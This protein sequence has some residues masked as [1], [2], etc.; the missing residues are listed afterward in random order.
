M[1]GLPASHGRPAAADTPL[2]LTTLGAVRLTRHRPGPEHH[3]P[4]LLPPGK[5]LALVTYLHCSPGR[6]ASRDHLIEQFWND[7]GQADGRHAL[8]Q[9][10]LRIRH[11]LGADALASEPD[12]IAL[13]MPIICDRDEFRKA[14]AA[15]QPDQAVEI[16][17]GDFFPAFASPGA[18]GFEQWADLERE[19]LRRSFLRAGEE[20]VRLALDRAAFAIATPAAL[21]LRTLCPN[22]QATWRLL[23]EAYSSSGNQ[24]AALVEADGLLAALAAMDD[25]PD[26]AT[27]RLLSELRQPAPVTSPPGPHDHD[28]NPLRSEMVGRE[29]PFA[30]LTAA[31]EHIQRRGAQHL[32][33]CSPPG[34]GKTRLLQELANR[35][36]HTPGCVILLRAAQGDRDRPGALIGDIATALAATGALSGAARD[37]LTELAPLAPTLSAFLD[38]RTTRV[39]PQGTR[40]ARV[41]AL[42]DLIGSVADNRPLALLLD[43]LHWGD[44]ESREII[45]GIIP[46]LTT[47][48]V[49]IVTASRDRWPDLST[50]GLTSEIPL[51]SLHESAI[52]GMLSSMGA[53]PADQFT[54]TFARALLRTS[55]GSPLLVL[56]LLRLAIEHGHVEALPGGWRWANRDEALRVVL[57]DEPLARRI[58]ALDEVSRDLLLHLAAAEVPLPM[59]YLGTLGPGAGAA[60]AQLDQVGLASSVAGTMAPAHD[61]VAAAVV[62]RASAEELRGAHHALGEWASSRLDFDPIAYQRAARHFR[63]AESHLALEQLFL[64]RVRLARRRREGVPLRDL[65]R[66][67]AGDDA[68]PAAARKLLRKLSVAERVSSVPGAQTGILTGAGVFAAIVLAG[69]VLS[70]A[71]TAPDARLLITMQDRE[72]ASTF[73]LHELALHRADWD[74]GEPMSLGE[75]R[76]LWRFPEGM[77]PYTDIVPHPEGRSFVF[78]HLFEDAG[79]VDLVLRDHRG[80]FRRLTDTRG[81]DFGPTW[82]PDGAHLAFATARWTPPDDRD[83][84]IAVLSLADD[85]IR[86]VTQGADYDAHPVWSPDGSRIAFSRRSATSGRSMPC[87]VTVDGSL[88]S[89]ADRWTAGAVRIVEWRSPDALVLFHEAVAGDG[90]LYRWHL[91]SGASEPLPIEGLNSNCRVQLEWLACFSGLPGVP[92]LAY[93]DGQESRTRPLSGI[94]A[95]GS[96]SGSWRPEISRGRYLARI[97]FSAPHLKATLGVSHQLWVAGHDAGGSRHPIPEGVVRWQ[98]TDT[99]VAAVDPLSGVLYPRQPGKVWVRVSAGGWRTDSVLVTIEPHEPRLVHH[100]Q[101]QD[102]A[103]A[104]WHLGGYPLPVVV[105][106]P[107]ETSALLNNGDDQFDSGAAS[108]RQFD[109]TR[110]VAVEAL[111]STPITAAK[112]QSLKLA[113]GSEAEWARSGFVQRSRTGAPGCVFSL[114][115][116]ESARYVGLAGRTSSPAPGADT[117]FTSLSSGRWYRILIQRFPDGSCGFAVDGIPLLRTPPMPGTLRDHQIMIAGQSVRTRMLVGPFEVWSGIRPGVDWSLVDPR[118]NRQDVPRP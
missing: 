13:L 81:D 35:L 102:D 17:G 38:P 62:A 57:E 77:R 16:Y 104:D 71:R 115:A 58:N 95:P 98:A 105:T 93:W 40:S 37:S 111:I 6:R 55:R 82:S 72:G 44:T 92:H 80:R 28:P 39:P 61:E 108:R 51:Q 97:S 41:P 59:D 99:T 22:E 53:D 65:A 34:F 90:R 101:W 18:A 109:G 7:S 89:C 33:L 14:V 12:G 96:E 91:P 45:C 73:T 69:A 8:R 42:V 3:N 49:L 60:V 87:W 1:P 27:R 68:S 56:N 84:D 117:L 85:G 25:Q 66:Q 79:G 47:A 106:G 19:Q 83:A 70:Q 114:P 74:A 20:V 94:G 10:V 15:G 11:H 76:H 86:Q 112:W 52:L 116:S 64:R 75:A 24:A 26:P 118:L 30:T 110:G 50:P 4:S 32:H 21:K 107:G 67:A 31:W 36:R 29:R 2:H 43:D 100:E 113:L 46:R 5:A 48:R 9:I 88:E 23:I 103:L 63:L 78:D 54:G